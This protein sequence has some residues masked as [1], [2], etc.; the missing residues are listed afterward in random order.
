MPQ[1]LMTCSKCRQEKSITAFES[2]NATE[3]AACNPP[4]PN[5]I[6]LSLA[7][8]NE[9][10][11]ETVE[12]RPEHSPNQWGTKYWRAEWISREKENVWMPVIDFTADVGAIMD[13]IIE[14]EAAVSW[15]GHCKTQRVFGTFRAGGPF[16]NGTWDFED[17]NQLAPA[18]CC[19]YLFARD[20][21]RR[22]V[23]EGEA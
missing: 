20:G 18:L 23:R 7:A 19:A 3:C 12:A 2:E 16:R 1:V 8:L 4:R 21:I 14:K 11:T 22:E 15:N 6:T 5:T 17:R 9:A 10:V 13:L